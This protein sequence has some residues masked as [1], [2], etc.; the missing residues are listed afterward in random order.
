M[1][2]ALT[3]RPAFTLDGISKGHR[4]QLRVLLCGQV[5]WTQIQWSGQGRKAPGR[6]SWERKGPSP[7]SVGIIPLSS[8]HWILSLDDGPRQHPLT[9]GLNCRP[10]GRCV[11]SSTLCWVVRART[12]RTG[13][14]ERDQRPSPQWMLGAGRPC[15]PSWGSTV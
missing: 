8:K 1:G 3:S 11:M 6:A 12:P 15:F 13:A 2:P 9:K 7:S 14:P 10:R 4:H 5:G